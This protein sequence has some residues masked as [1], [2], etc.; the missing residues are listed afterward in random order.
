MRN[1]SIL[2]HLEASSLPWPQQFLEGVNMLRCI[3]RESATTCHGIKPR[4]EWEPYIPTHF[5]YAFFT[6]NTLYN[7]D[8]Q[9]SVLLGAIINFDSE[10][11]TISSS[12]K[13][14]TERGKINEYLSYCFKNKEFITTYKKGFIMYITSHYCCNDIL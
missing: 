2:S 8:W 4:G 7:I 13:P 3:H 14:L 9:Q 11:H 6:F 1:N 10:K 12:G 5:I